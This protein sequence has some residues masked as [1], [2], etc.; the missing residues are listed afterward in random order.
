MKTLFINFSYIDNERGLGS[1]VRTRIKKFIKEKVYGHFRGK[2][3]YK[4][5]PIGLQNGL[6]SSKIGTI[7]Q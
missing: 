4:K 2:S 3:S 5:R 7:D 1:E 6:T